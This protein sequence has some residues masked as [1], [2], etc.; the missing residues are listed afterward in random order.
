MTISSL[1]VP[2]DKWVSLVMGIDGLG[3]A[4]ILAAFFLEL[5]TGVAASLLV[6]KEDYSS[7][8]LARFSVKT[9]CYLVL[10]CVPYMLGQ[11]MMSAK[12][13]VVANVGGTALDWMSVF[14]IF[15]ITQENIVS[16]L[17]NLAVISG[18]EKT[19][20]ITAIT[21]KFKS[22]LDEKV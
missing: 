11:S 20:W 9:A 14:L 17:E 13:G 16:V 18:K 15:Q 10:I 8:R 19:A 3:F 7:L 5:T 12:R 4:A 22:V 2:F 1:L 6:Q 21:N